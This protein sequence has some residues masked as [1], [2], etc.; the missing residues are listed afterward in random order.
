MLEQPNKKGFQMKT[1]SI[2]KEKCTHCG[3][4]INDCL[5]GCIAFDN[6]NYPQMIDETRCISCQ[7]CLAICP[8][9]ALSFCGKKPENSEEV[10]YNDIFSLIKSRRSV[11]QY[12]NEEISNEKMSKLKD[13]L[14]YV[15]TGCNSH[16][17][18]FSIVEEKSAM[19]IIRKR[20]NEL[21][22][23][24]L[25]YK[26]ISP[27][28]NKFSRYKDALL[29]GED[30]IFR[31]APHMI[32]ASSP[33]SAPCAAVDPVIALSYFE[34]CA[35]NLGVGTCWCGFGEVCLKFFPEICDMLE[36]PSG[37]KPVYVML[38]GPPAVKYRRT[39]QPEPYKIAEIK[40]IHEKDSCFFC[41]AKRLI[42]NFLR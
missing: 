31:G 2:D 17:L 28:V 38:F 22:V 19:D 14:N 12:K 40:E 5:S 11:R 36:I 9:G 6:E 4:C 32:V 13:M 33:L 25:S 41:K 26:A 18:H 39:I 35:Q 23:K 10:E 16:S 37:Y 20:V 3:L 42:T 21:L 8:V 7:H 24:T 1:I 29:N 34:L 27:L 15:P 30:V